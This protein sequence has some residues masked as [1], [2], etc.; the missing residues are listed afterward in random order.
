MGTQHQEGLFVDASRG[1][2]YLWRTVEEG[3]DRWG[4]VV[5]LKEEEKK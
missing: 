2:R 4:A 1:W 5:P 3:R